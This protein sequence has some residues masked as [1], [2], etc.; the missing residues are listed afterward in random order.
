MATV[1]ASTTGQ[2]FNSS[3]SEISFKLPEG[4]RVQIVHGNCTKNKIA[5]AIRL[6][7]RNVFNIDDYQI[8]KADK[9]KI[10]SAVH[11]KKNIL[12][13]GGTGTGKTSF[14]NCLINNYVAQKERLIT[15]EGVE[16]LAINHHKNITSLIYQE[17]YL[18]CENIN[19]KIS[20]LLNASLR[21]R[22]DRII[23]GELRKENAILN[24]DAHKGVIGHLKEILELFTDNRIKSVTSDF[25]AQDYRQIS[26]VFGQ[27]YISIFESNC[28]YK[29]I[30]KQNNF[31]TAQ[32]IS[33]TIGNQTID[34]VSV[35]KGISHQNNLKPS[36]NNSNSSK[37][38]SFNKEGLALITEQDILNLSKSQCLILVQGHAG[39]PILGNNALWFKEN[40]L[41][42]LINVKS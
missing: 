42:K 30:F 12:V 11:S 31:Q 16:E 29:I 22:P 40:K 21:M 19:S 37:S 15:I 1:M 24:G 10:I 3:T 9:E 14:L 39:K 36:F 7:G 32:S 2:K 20:D 23:L 18:K 4:H 26:N 33:K 34:K 41:K 25:V 38:Q 27:S 35:N 6:F 8:S 17:S 28:A 13:S 5:M